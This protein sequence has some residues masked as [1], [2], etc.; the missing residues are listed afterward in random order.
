MTLVVPGSGSALS[1][2]RTA[3]SVSMSRA[4]AS[5][6]TTATFSSNCWYAN[7]STRLRESSLSSATINREFRASQ[8]FRMSLRTLSLRS[9]VMT[10]PCSGTVLHSESAI[11]S[12]VSPISSWW[13]RRTFVITEMGER[14]MTFWHRFWYLGFTAMHSTTRPLTEPSSH[15]FKKSYCSLMFAGPVR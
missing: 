3:T 13:S 9:P 14:R 7:L 11:S 15:S 12:T 6:N 1:M 8:F 4:S 5:A 2:P 10:R